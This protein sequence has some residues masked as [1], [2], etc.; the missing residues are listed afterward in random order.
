MFKQSSHNECSNNACNNQQLCCLK[1]V[2]LSRQY[3]RVPSSGKMVK[4]IWSNLYNFA[5]FVKKNNGTGTYLVF[6]N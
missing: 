4:R 5:G 2:T 1:M 3:C 6:V